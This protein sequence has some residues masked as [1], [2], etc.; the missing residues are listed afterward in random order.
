MI[1]LGPLAD[2]RF[3]DLY[4]I[5]YMRVVGKPGFRA[6]AGKRPDTS[7]ITYYRILDHTVGKNGDI[8]TG[9]HIAHDHVGA[10]AD[11]VTE[12][13]F[14]LQDRVNIDN[15]ILAG[16]QRAAQVESIRIYQRHP[17]T[18]AIHCCT[19]LQAALL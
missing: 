2:I 5:T 8:V 9:N 16:M 18:H 3:L 11:P 4:K 10:D 13:D 7:A 12:A 6:Q 14:A 17:G 19:T 15:Y 1:D